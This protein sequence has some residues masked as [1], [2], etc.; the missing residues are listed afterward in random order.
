MMNLAQKN[1]Q[2]YRKDSRGSR[3][4]PVT[5]SFEHGKEINFGFSKVKHTLTKRKTTSFYK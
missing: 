5:E 3:Q 1:T 4:S 2:E